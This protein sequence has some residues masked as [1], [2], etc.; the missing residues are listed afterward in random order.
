M[1]ARVRLEGILRALWESR[2]T[3]ATITAYGIAF[4]FLA[5]QLL[6]YYGIS[7][8][9]PRELIWNLLVYLIPTRLLVGSTKQQELRSTGMLSQTHA[10]KSEALR[11]AFGASGSAIMQSITGTDTNTRSGGLFSSLRQ[12]SPNAPPGLG[13]WD[14][15]CYQNSILQG[16][17]SLETVKTYLN[18][19]KLDTGDNKTSTYGALRELITKLNDPTNNG[20]QLW[21]PAKLKSMSSWTQQD[22]QEYF[23]K[24]MDELDKEVADAKPA[25]ETKPGLQVVTDKEEAST[26][27]EK[28][29]QKSEKKDP[30]KVV[31]SKNPLEGLLAQRVACM[32]CGFS[33]GLSMIPFNCLTVP[34]GDESVYGVEDCLD[35]Y[36]KLEEISEV[37]CA[38]CTLLKAQ[39]HLQA[40]VGADS[41]KTA[42]D[43]EQKVISLP[44]ALQAISAKRLEAVERALEKDDFADKTL[45]ETCQISK[46][47]HVSSTKTRQ[48]VIGRAPQS[49]AIHIN[50]SVFDE[51]TGMQRKN[52]AAVQYPLTLDLAPWVLDHDVKDE[53]TRTS[54][55]SSTRS[56]IT[57]SASN[58]KYPYQLRA[59]V[60]HFGRHENG[61]YIAYRQHPVINKISASA[62]EDEGEQKLAS[63]DTNHEIPEM[64]WWR[65]SD[66]DVDTVSEDEVLRQGGVFMLFYER[67]DVVRTFPTN[68]GSL[69]EPEALSTAKSYA[70]SIREQEE[71]AAIPLPQD[72]DDSEDFG[73]DEELADTEAK[74][75]PDA[76]G[77]RTTSITNS[78]PSDDDPPAAA[79]NP[80]LQPRSPHPPAIPTDQ[81]SPIMATS[82]RAVE[83]SPLEAPAAQTQQRSSTQPLMRTARRSE[84]TRRA[85]KGDK[86]FGGTSLRPMAAT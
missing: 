14:N 49:L 15:S 46:K 75:R 76:D 22:A 38:K 61:H 12:A 5:Y 48:A 83:T 45:S 8:L 56:L 54:A 31:T 3:A 17:A 72:D 52:H 4:F 34:L 82:E 51:R 9:S 74:A 50:R 2:P 85:S 25:A 78:A 6:N 63:T 64:K 77:L 65:L 86:G 57:E 28:D 24:I 33:E 69:V 10:A 18:K 79:E 43:V 23:S 21:T 59:V 11:K 67:D 47:A 30:E 73:V 53:P 62:V 39:K 16:L 80:T 26:V 58:P 20:K 29:V 84:A 35:E 44:P 71:A 42:P 19:A 1:D 32:R 81:R 55:A 40:C 60:T 7:L 70:L 66:D 36:A 68:L 41:E 13:N 27:E 37:E